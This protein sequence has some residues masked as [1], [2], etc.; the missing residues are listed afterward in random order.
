MEGLFV[1]ILSFFWRGRVVVGEHS[2]ANNADSIYCEEARGRE[3]TRP[4][5][6]FGFN[7]GFI[8]GF[9]WGWIVASLGYFFS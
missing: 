6:K 5:K 1:S 8:F 4:V 9:N 3:F 7:W 2:L